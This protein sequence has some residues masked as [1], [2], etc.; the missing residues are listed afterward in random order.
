[1]S[2]WLFLPIMDLCLLLAQGFMVFWISVLILINP[3]T[4]K[5]SSS[6][7]TGPYSFV[8]TWDNGDMSD[9]DLHLRTPGGA[10]VFFGKPTANGSY[11]DVDDVGYNIVGS[12]K[13]VINIVDCKEGEY[14]CLIHAFYLRTSESPIKLQFINNETGE[15]KAEKVITLEYSNQWETFLRVIMDKDGKVIRVYDMEFE[16]Y[17]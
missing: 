10:T 8:M 9:I 11:L 6:I 16:V 15:V 5:E 7:P 17:K 14:I 3:P 2:K 1:M 12:N 13:E 4:K